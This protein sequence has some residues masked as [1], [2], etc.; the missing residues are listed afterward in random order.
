MIDSP[1]APFSAEVT[2][3]AAGT[4]TVWTTADRVRRIEIRAH[5]GHVHTPNE[6]RPNVLNEALRQLREYF[7]GNRREFD[8]PLDLPER[9]TGFQRAVYKLL[10]GVRFGELTTYGEIAR[11]IGRPGSARAVG[12]AVGANPIPLVI[13]CHRVVG[14]GGRLT[15]FGSGVPNKVR[16]L[17]LEGV[18]AS[19]DSPSSYVEAFA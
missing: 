6:E 11:E 4:V 12:G 5:S 14:S 1:P 3:T 16:L 17:A 9:T 7:D 2:D 8:L 13:P 10:A 19:G 15:G 18:C